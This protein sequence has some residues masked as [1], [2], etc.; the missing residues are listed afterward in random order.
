[1]SVTAAGLYLMADGLRNR[2]NS[3]QDGIPYADAFPWALAAAGALISTALVLQRFPHLDWRATGRRLSSVFA[4][5]G[6]IVT[7]G[8]AIARGVAWASANGWWASRS[9]WAVWLIVLGLVLALVSLT[10]RL[11]ISNDP[12][13]EAP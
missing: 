13:P 2:P 1:M 11:L 7:G 8:L 6:Y 5:A 4:I 3:T 12:D 10:I 9:V